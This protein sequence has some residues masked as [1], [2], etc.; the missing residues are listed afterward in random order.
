MRNRVIPVVYFSALLALMLTLAPEARAQQPPVQVDPQGEVTDEQLRAFT[1]AYIDVQVIGQ[2][3]QEMLTAVES[4]EQAQAL[5]Q[6]AQ[7]AMTEAVQA[8]GLE[9]QEYTA[10]AGVLNEDEA[11]RTRF[12]GVLAELT[13][14][15]EVRN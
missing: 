5:Q 2:E 3:H 1:L 8:Q 10:I 14:A 13:D 4:A 11:L 15:E 7:V 6:R 9:P 12:A